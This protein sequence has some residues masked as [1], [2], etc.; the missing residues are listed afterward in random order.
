MCKFPSSTSP[1]LAM[2]A[3][4]ALCTNSARLASSVVTGKK[5]CASVKF[6]GA[7][8]G[9]SERRADSQSGP[10]LR[11]KFT[12]GELLRRSTKCAHKQSEQA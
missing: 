2:A 1:A 6:F 5:T 12:R 4:A 9:S 10:P 8:P 11:F 3:A 7:F